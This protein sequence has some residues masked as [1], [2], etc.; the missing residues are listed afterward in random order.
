MLF[1]ICIRK[2]IKIMHNQKNLQIMVQKKQNSERIYS[3]S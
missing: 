2:P 3:H 1:L